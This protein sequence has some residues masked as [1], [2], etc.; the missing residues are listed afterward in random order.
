MYLEFHT[1]ADGTNP[2]KQEVLTSFAKLGLVGVAIDGSSYGVTTPVI[3]K[4]AIS[5]SA[6][7][8]VVLVAD[9]DGSLAQGE[10]T[11]TIC[12][13]LARTIN[14]DLIADEYVRYAP[15]HSDEWVEFVELDPRRQAIDQPAGF[16]NE[17]RLSPAHLTTKAIAFSESETDTA[18][19][20]IAKDTDATVISI[21]CPEGRIIQLP[22]GIV[23]LPEA[24]NVSPRR[25][26]LL[27][28]GG[29]AK[30]ATLQVGH[31]K[32]Q[33]NLTLA[34]LPRFEQAHQ[35]PH[36]SPAALIGAQISA[37]AL[38][39]GNVVTNHKQF[40]ENYLQIAAEATSAAGWE[41]FFALAA[42]V[43]G[44]PVLTAELMDQQ[45]EF[46]A[47]PDLR[48]T[49]PDTSGAALLGSELLA[50]PTGNG[51]IAKIAKKLYAKPWLRLTVGALWLIAGILGLI[52]HEALSNTALPSWF[53]WVAG[54]L[55][56]LQGVS[57]TLQATL[58]LIL[59][60]RTPQP[61][62]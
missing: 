34:N 35:Y 4:V 53:I 16:P 7:D 47:G 58:Q 42:Q 24:T 36:D 62:G 44:A 31:G 21:S 51:F 57:E 11:G 60:G 54:V 25:T 14:T 40:P 61:K 49:A 56:T 28:Q 46:P 18:A 52:F 13:R 43:F 38:V 27:A 1:R 29:R 26:V 10:F 30:F 45:R 6:D 32:N 9:Q 39:S 15:G 8:S 55:C 33:L 5:A 59:R 19:S 37:G 17:W 22:S 41:N 50:P 12:E 3:A 23:Q 48:E 2:S 20:L